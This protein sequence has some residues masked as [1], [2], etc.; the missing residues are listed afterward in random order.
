MFEFFFG[1]S[2]IQNVLSELFGIIVTI[3]FVDTLY[4]YRRKQQGL[5]YAKIL[6]TGIRNII[7][8]TVD[9][10]FGPLFGEEFLNLETI[11]SPTHATK[12][13][14]VVTSLRKQNEKVEQYLERYSI[15]ATPELVALIHEHVNIIHKKLNVLSMIYTLQIADSPMKDDERIPQALFE[16]PRDVT[17]NEIL[18]TLPALEE[19]TIAKHY[20]ELQQCYSSLSHA[21]DQ[22]FTKQISFMSTLLHDSIISELFLRI[23][24]NLCKRQKEQCI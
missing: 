17:M 7:E 20:R 13:F 9:T 21:L 22:E 11:Q 1:G 14:M 19:Q 15:F 6:I 18:D 5:R 2:M 16:G 12:L 8:D 10:A 24:M 3:F 4:E 23:K